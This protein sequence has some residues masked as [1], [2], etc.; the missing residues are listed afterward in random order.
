MHPAVGRGALRRRGHQQGMSTKHHV[1]RGIVLV[2]EGRRLFQT[3]TVLENLRLGAYLPK[4][5]TTY[6]RVARAG[7]QPVPGAQGAGER[8]GRPAERRRAADAGHRPGGHG[9]SQGGHDR[10]GVSGAQPHPHPQ[11][12]RADRGSQ[13]AG[14]HRA[15]GRA[16]HPHGSE[17]LPQGVRHE[18]RAHHDERYRGRTAGQ[19]RTCA[20]RMSASGGARSYDV[21]SSRSS[22]TVCSWGRCTASRPPA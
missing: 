10:R 7:V 22:S 1:D 3:L 12:L 18:D 8:Q 15:A 20:R 6:R 4:A 13:R 21:A 16:E 19:C 5:R 14:H 17:G 9:P 2:P 11:D